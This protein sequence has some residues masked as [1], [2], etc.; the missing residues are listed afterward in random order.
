MIAKVSYSKEYFSKLPVPTISPIARKQLRDLALRLERIKQREKRAY[1]LMHALIK[2]SKENPELV[3]KWVK[4]RVPEAKISLIAPITPTPPGFVDWVKSKVKKAYEKTKSAFSKAK[5]FIV[6][7]ARKVVASAKWF[8]S[9]A[10]KAIGSVIKGVGKAA[11]S[12]IRWLGEKSK[13][14]KKWFETKIK[15]LKERLKKATPEERPYLEQQ[16]KDL[17]TANIAAQA[18]SEYPQAIA[19][20]AALQAEEAT[21]EL[22]L[23]TEKFKS[24]IPLVLIGAL[25]LALGIY[26][27]K[28]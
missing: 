16:I 11:Y 25:V 13:A 21:S 15:S 1:K 27:Y 3:E 10:G 22:S 6:N 14:A 28:K 26:L 5:N 23:K 20:E 24:L 9:K 4:S 2:A 19:Q 18:E 17:E 7:S 8:A 12:S